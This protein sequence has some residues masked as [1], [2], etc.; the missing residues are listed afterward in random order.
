MSPA[1]P[2][3]AI[4]DRC[5]RCLAP[6][7]A[8][9]RERVPIASREAPARPL[10]L[11]SCSARA[12]VRP[13]PPRSA[14]KVRSGVQVID[15]CAG[16]VSTA[17]WV[18]SARRMRTGTG[19]GIRCLHSDRPVPRPRS[20]YASPLG[21][22][23]KKTRYVPTS[24]YDAPASPPAGHAVTRTPTRVHSGDGSTAVPYRSR[25]PSRYAEPP[26]L[27]ARPGRGTPRPYRT[28]QPVA[29]P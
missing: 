14:P 23:G 15:A 22:H 29:A 4:A 10:G 18:P 7:T 24:S 3:S 26:R 8:R 9:R 20:T 16:I 21:S 6:C 12:A 19:S 2:R 5:G 11:V 27:V 1:T 17:P 25:S 28:T 13:P